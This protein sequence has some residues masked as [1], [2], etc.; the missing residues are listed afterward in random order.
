[1]ADHVVEVISQEPVGGSDKHMAVTLTE[2]KQT[3]HGSVG[4]KVVKA[5]NWDEQALNEGYWKGIHLRKSTE[6]RLFLSG[7][8]AGGDVN[9]TYVHANENTSNQVVALVDAPKPLEP[10]TFMDLMVPLDPLEQ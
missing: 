4:G 1:M 2:R 8:I 5:R 9:G 7:V 10:T 6:S 3:K